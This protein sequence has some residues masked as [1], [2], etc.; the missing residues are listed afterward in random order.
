MTDIPDC[1]RC[2]K[3]PLPPEDYAYKAGDEVQYTLTSIR[4]RSCSISTRT[5]RITAMVSDTVAEV[6][7]ANGQRR[8]F[9]VSRLRPTCYPS[10]LYY[11]LDGHCTCNDTETTTGQEVSDHE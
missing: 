10:P 9:H 8:K 4:G 7:I 5:G 11:M 1:P 6:K 2:G 3:K